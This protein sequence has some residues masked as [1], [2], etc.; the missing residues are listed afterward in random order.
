VGRFFDLKRQGQN[1]FSFN[2]KLK[3]Y[4]DKYGFCM[5]IRSSNSFQPLI[6]EY[7]KLNDSKVYYSMWNGYLDCEK[8]AFNESLYNFL[9]PYEIEHMHTS[10][11]A[12]LDTL[13]KVFETVKPKGGIIPI[14]TEAPEKFQELFHEQAAIIP[15]H[16]GDVFDVK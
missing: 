1:P 12:D 10:G 16:D 11:H 13:K 6:D 4:L 8:P 15:L 9:E 2:G 5:L 14:H 3:S 7:A